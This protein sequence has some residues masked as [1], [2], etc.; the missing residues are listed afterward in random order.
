VN[1]F[2]SHDSVASFLMVMLDDIVQLVDL[3]DN[4]NSSALVAVLSRFDNPNISGPC[5]AIF[6][7]LLP[8][9]LLPLLVESHKSTVL[10]IFEPILDMESQRNIIE[11]ILAYFTVVVFQIVKKSLF[12]SEVVV[13]LEMVVN[14]LWAFRIL[15][16][17]ALILWFGKR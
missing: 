17:Y 14:Y 10:T 13:V 16:G 15:L 11:S 5:I 8:N 4:S 3:I 2:L 12:V 6:L 7:L 9:L 1:W